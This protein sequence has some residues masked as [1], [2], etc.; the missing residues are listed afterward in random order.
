M[1]TPI[2]HIWQRKMEG[3]SSADNELFRVLY[4]PL[5]IS[6]YS[7]LKQKEDAQDTASE[8]MIKVVALTPA[9]GVKNVRTWAI[10]ACKNAA[11]TKIRLDKRRREIVAKEMPEKSERAAI[12]DE[13]VRLSQLEETINASL[14]ALDQKI[15]NLHMQGFDNVEIAKA[16]TM[17]PK[18]VANRK[19]LIRKT[20]MKKLH[21]WR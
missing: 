21:D 17:I 18:T 5:I 15:W 7:I 6:A 4:P 19:S 16:C 2:E 13:K 8:T 20:L 1:A 12:A 10:T 14:N 11:L 9:D 3:D